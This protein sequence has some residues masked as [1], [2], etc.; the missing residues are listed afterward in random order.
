MDCNYPF[1][2]SD[3]PN[4][5]STWNIFKHDPATGRNIICNDRVELRIIWTPTRMDCVW[6]SIKL[7]V[8]C[9]YT[10]PMHKLRHWCW[11][12]FMTHSW[13]WLTHICIYFHL[14][15]PPPL[16]PHRQESRPLPINVDQCHH[17]SCRGG[18]VWAAALPSFCLWWER[19]QWQWRSRSFHYH[20][21][22]ECRQQAFK[23]HGQT[24]R[25]HQGGGTATI[26]T[27]WTQCDKDNNHWAGRRGR[28]KGGMTLVHS[29]DLGTEDDMMLLLTTFLN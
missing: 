17:P 25:W 24:F 28:G 1:P 20:C 16:P 27:A 9:W 19:R 11:I 15:Y 23:I 8:T 18:I 5:C 29:C 21:C 2:S 14:L 6:S 10:W 4:C 26:I 3:Q 12:S 22:Q 7:S 13:A